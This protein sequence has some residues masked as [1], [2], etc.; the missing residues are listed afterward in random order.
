MSVFWLGLSLLVMQRWSSADGDGASVA[1]I[2]LGVGPVIRPDFTVITLI[3]LGVLVLGQRGAT[4]ARHVKVVGLGAAIPVL[5]EIFRILYF[6]ALVPNTY[7]A[8][9][10]GDANWSQGWLYLRDFVGPYRLWIPV[11]GLVL[12]AVVPLIVHLRERSEV[13]GALVVVAFPLSGFVS[14]LAIVRGG[15]DFMHARLLLP[16]LFAIV[17]P[18]ATVAIRRRTA[19][20][21]ALLPWAAVCLVALAPPRFSPDQ[22]DGINDHRAGL[23][24]MLGEQNL[25]T[26]EDFGFA[27]GGLNHFELDEEHRLY[28]GQTPLE[29]D[30]TPVPLTPDAPDRVVVAYGVGAISYFVGPDTYVLDM[31]GLGDTLAARLRLDGRGPLPGHE[32]ALPEEWVWARYIDPRVDP[33]PAL[34]DAPDILMAV[35]PT[36]TA[37]QQEQRDFEADVDAARAA[38]RCPD[39]EQ[40]TETPQ[41][42]IGPDQMIDAASSA[43]TLF[44]LRVP[45]D[46]IEAQ[47]QL[48]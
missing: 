41:R 47:D 5:Y 38:M 14:A 20:A 21:M 37:R 10:G 9:E 8:K 34:L 24:A 30:G 25:V 27:P 15:G 39:V 45:P 6:G 29:I 26:I 31:L 35:S 12:T 11:A 44:A 13:R 17:A 22:L 16:S 33:D 36:L 7:L 32:K 48:C 3:M 23:L 42:G 19:P 18:V 1:A 43:L 4:V 2:V 28:F 46:P 40:L